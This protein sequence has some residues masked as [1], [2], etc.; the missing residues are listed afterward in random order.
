MFVSVHC[1]DNVHNVKANRVELLGIY[2]AY[3][4]F[5]ECKINIHTNTFYSFM[6][7]LSILYYMFIYIYYMCILLYIL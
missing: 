2:T 3:L 4:S 6:Q 5:L 7:F 1:V